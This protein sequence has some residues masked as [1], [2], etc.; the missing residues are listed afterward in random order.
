[1]MSRIFN[2][3]LLPFM[4]IIALSQLISGCALFNRPTK[5]PTNQTLP[6]SHNQTLQHWQLKGKLIFKSPAE[7]FS[8]NLLWQQQGKLSDIRLN[9]FL[10][11]SIL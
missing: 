6:A 7:K 5:T 2:R 3:K 8:A 9:T 4:M 1:M 10:G 11:I